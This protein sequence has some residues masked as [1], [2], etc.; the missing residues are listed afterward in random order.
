MMPMRIHPLLAL[1]LYDMFL[2][3]EETN[4]P[5]TETEWPAQESSLMEEANSDLAN[6]TE[7]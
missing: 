3:C 6:Q 1:A 4:D 2:N 7:N 5:G